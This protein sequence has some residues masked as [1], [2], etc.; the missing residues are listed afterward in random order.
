M[1]VVDAFGSMYVKSMVVVD[2]ASDG[3]V[4]LKA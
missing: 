2:K 4:L 1:R 3:T